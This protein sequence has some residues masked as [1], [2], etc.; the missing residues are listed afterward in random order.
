MLPEL[1]DD[2]GSVLPVRRLSKQNLIT[3]DGK[4]DN[5]GTCGPVRVCLL[6]GIF[7]IAFV[8]R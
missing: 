4:H 3:A 8:N 2:G 1:P 5:I 7:A 6:R